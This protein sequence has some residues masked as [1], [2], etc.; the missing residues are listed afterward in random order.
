[1]RTSYERNFLGFGLFLRLSTIFT[2]TLLVSALDIEKPDPK[3]H[4]F[5]I[6]PIQNLV[7]ITHIPLVHPTTKNNQVE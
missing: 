2:R 5:V 1:M 3:L 4:Q 7:A 6:I